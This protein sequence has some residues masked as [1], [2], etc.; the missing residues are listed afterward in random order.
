MG[1]RDMRLAEQFSVLRQD[2][3]AIKPYLVLS[4]ASQARAMREAVQAFSGY[5]PKACILTKLDET[6]N[7]GVALSTLIEQRLPLA[8]VSDGQQVPE[9]LHPARTHLL[10]DQ[11]FADSAENIEDDHAGGRMFAYE[12]WV[13]HANV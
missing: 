8:Y 11:C 4:A 1:Q 13:A 12:D 2:D 10:L 3:M 6:P 9:D 7:L 5:E